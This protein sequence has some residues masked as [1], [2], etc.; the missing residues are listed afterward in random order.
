[1]SP[2][3]HRYP[4]VESFTTALAFDQDL[5][6]LMQK[7]TSRGVVSNILREYHGMTDRRTIAEAAGNIKSFVRQGLKFLDQA[8][9]GPRIVSFLPNYYAL[10]QLAKAVI[11]AR[12]GPQITSQLLSHGLSYQPTAKDSQ[13]LGSEEL[14]IW[15]RG[16]FGEYY[17]I[18]T[19]MRLPD[20]RRR[21]G[22]RQNRPLL[23]VRMKNVYPFLFDA[24]YEFSSASGESPSSFAQVSLYSA[25]EGSERSYSLRVEGPK[26]LTKSSS[27]LFRSFGVEGKSIKIKPGVALEDEFPTYLLYYPL[28]QSSV[29]VPTCFT[30]LW[31]DRL[32]YPEEIPLFLSFFHLGSIVRYKPQFMERVM[33]SPYCSF[34]LAMER[35]CATKFCLLF[36]EAMM[37]ATYLVQ[38]S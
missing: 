4:R 28:V 33:D 9:N 11:V 5:L 14:Q 20:F 25:G 26:G 34:L 15:P 30:P 6:D 2:M 8:R 24:G 32:H 36:L 35:H 17:Q 22:K 19:K 3:V 29:F 27:P 21:N 7:F 16:V 31:R 37:Q 38:T 13:T 18:H 1:M 10:L 23:R 12:R